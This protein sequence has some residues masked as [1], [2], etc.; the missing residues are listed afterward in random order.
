[1]IIQNTIKQ[2]SQILKKHNIDTHNLDAEII[3]ANLMRVQREF[4]ILN[5]NSYITNIHSRNVSH[6]LRYENH[7]IL[8]SY[9]TINNDNPKLNC[10]L[11]GLEKFSPIRIIIDKDLKINLNSQIVKNSSNLKTIIFHNSNNNLKINNLKKKGLKLIQFR[12]KKGN[13][14]DMKKILKKIYELGIHTLLV[15]SGS[16]L[17]YDMLS[18]KLFNEFYLFKSD[19]SIKNKDKINIMNIIKNLDKK[20]KNKKIVNTYLDKDELLHYY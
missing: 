19:K 7:G 3:L 18:N 2:A 17:I 5:N 8:T 12:A 9:K 14:F 6:L 13:Y 1:M 16:A 20:F 11:N 10:R 15:E 4:F